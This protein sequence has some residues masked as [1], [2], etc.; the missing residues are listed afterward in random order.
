MI[1]KSSDDFET[2]LF[3]YSSYVDGHIRKSNVSNLYKKAAT[4][5]TINDLTAGHY[6]TYCG[7]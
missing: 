6:D 1:S 5:T 4:V 3:W 2:S 7:R